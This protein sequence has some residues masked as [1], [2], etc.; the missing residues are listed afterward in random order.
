[1]R[2]LDH[3]QH[4]ATSASNAYLARQALVAI[5]VR[6]LLPRIGVPTLV[7]H[8]LGDRL[9]SFD[10]GR[11]LATHI[12]GARLVALES[13]NHILLADEPAWPVLVREV[14]SFLAPDRSAIAV[15]GPTTAL[16]ER[17]REVLSLAARGLTND[18]IAASLHLS[19]RTV[20][21][22]LQNAYTRL[23]VSGRTARA[24]AVSRLLS[25]L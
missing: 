22:H 4:V 24:A 20:E 14:E 7:L 15:K 5:D 17:E 3:L 21:R 12:P 6:R 9:T 19:V 18:E 25:S 1:M 10:K 13:D 8:S 23:G 16:S 11:L 2:W